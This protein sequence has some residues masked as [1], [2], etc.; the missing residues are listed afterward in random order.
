M[1][2]FWQFDTNG[3]SP[4]S[5]SSENTESD[6]P[7]VI[8]FPYPKA[9][10]SQLRG[11]GRLGVVG[12]TGSHGLLARCAGQPARTLPSTGPSGH[13]TANGILLQ[14]FNRLQNA[15]RV[16]LAHPQDRRNALGPPRRPIRPGWKTAIRFAGRITAGSFLW[17]SERDGW[18]HAYLAGAD[19]QGLSRVTEGDLDVIQVEAVDA[20]RGWLYYAASPD[21]PTQRY[22]YRR[23]FTRRDTGAV[24]SRRA[25]RLA[26][27]RHR[28]R[29]ALHRDAV[30]G[31]VARNLRGPQHDATLLRSAHTL[32]ARKPANRTKPESH[33]HRTHHAAHRAHRRGVPGSAWCGEAGSVLEPT[34]N[35]HLSVAAPTLIASSPCVR[36]LP[37]TWHLSMN[38]IDP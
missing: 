14:Q 3:V 20:V 26:H 17:L 16:M 27:L 28:A 7:Q 36:W 12:T 8:S 25:T 34:L 30:S 37:D 33:P 1:I 15:N 22:L 13:P 23:A 29:Q 38:P 6:Y 18:R 10:R 11:K 4:G 2:V 19:G 32:S 9:G 5:T 31:P 35:R 21:D 24:V